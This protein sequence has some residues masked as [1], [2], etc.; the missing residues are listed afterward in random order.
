MQPGVGAAHHDDSDAHQHEGEQGSDAGHVSQGGDGGE[1]GENSC[2]EHEQ[3]VRAPGS[4]E[5]GVDVAEYFGKQPVAG[6]GEEHPALTQQHH[7]DHRGEAQNDGELDDGPHPHVRGA[8]DGDGYRRGYVQVFVV[9]DSCE[10]VRK[11]D[12][13][14]GA[15][16]Q[17]SDDAHGHVFLWLARLLRGGGDGIET[18]ERE[19]D[20]ARATQHSAEA[21]LTGDSGIGRDEGSIVGAVDVGPAQ[22]DEQHRRGNFQHDDH[23]VDAGRFLNTQ[24]EDQ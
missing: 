13:N 2:E 19:E 9:H 23:A 15:D 6:H 14:D 10:H 17:R 24:D 11:H 12:V 20:F 8:V 22:H 1:G 4:S 3:K 5:L 21:K 16:R 18:D 7:Q